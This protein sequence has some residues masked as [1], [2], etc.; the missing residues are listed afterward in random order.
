MSA[1]K[2]LALAIEVARRQRDQADQALMQARRA[3]QFAQGQLDQLQSYAADT[4]ARWATA[5]A[6]NVSAELMQHH[7][8]F[9]QRLRHAI[10]LQDGV[11]ADLQRQVETARQR[12]VQEE[13]RLAAFEQLMKKKLSA[14][15]QLEARR[16]QKQ[17]DEL[18]GLK[19]ARA[20]AAGRGLMTGDGS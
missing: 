10:G 9:M 18:A 6:V 20:A 4:E 8:H 16:E 5:T 7:Q 13:V 14:Q 2:S 12:R 3:V 19:Y 1:V 15:A 17:M 11:M